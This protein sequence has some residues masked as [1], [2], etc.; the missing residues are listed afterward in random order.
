MK[1]FLTAAILLATMAGCE[2]PDTT[3]STHSDVGLVTV[4]S[5]EY[6]M[7]RGLKKGGI[8]HHENCHN[9]K[10]LTKCDK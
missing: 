3:N 2:R 7:Y 4:D 1:L 10:H 8:I 6:V 9:P 5:C